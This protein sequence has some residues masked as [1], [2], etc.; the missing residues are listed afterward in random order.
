[1]SSPLDDPPNFPVQET[2]TGCSGPGVSGMNL[3]TTF[4]PIAYAG[5]VE[6]IARAGGWTVRH[7][8]PTES[9]PRPWFQ[10]AAPEGSRATPRLYLSAGI[11]GDEIAGPVALLELIRQTD[12]FAGLDVTMFPILN[13]NGLARGVRTNWDEIDL[14]R[15]YRNSRSLEIKSHIETLLT[16]GRFDASM[17]LHEDYEGIG[18]YLYELNDSLDPK[19]GAKIIAAMGRHVPIDLRP[20]IE[21]GVARG[22]VISRRDLIGKLGR[23]EDRPEW[24]EAIYLAVHHTDVSFTTETPK[25][26]PIE[27]RVKAQIAAVGTLV[28]ALK[29]KI[30]PL[31]GLNLA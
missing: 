24:A 25:P 21:E 4:D 12:F 18:A 29:G 8:P 23:L 2:S 20:E 13:P 30:D 17:L 27:A 14:N 9:G 22:G 16:L 1:M 31:Q 15:D 11:H 19:L 10:R 6:E 26:Y 28:E 3:P 7:L 5:E